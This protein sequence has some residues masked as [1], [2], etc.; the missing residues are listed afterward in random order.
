MSNAV[1]VSIEE[2]LPE[3]AWFSKVEAFVLKILSELNKSDWELSVFFC[4]DAY[5][6]SLNKE[7]R[8]I[9]SATDI[10]SFE[11][12]SEDFPQF[13][14]ADESEPYYAGDI[15]ISLE[16]LPVNAE[17]FGIEKTL[18]LQRLLIHGVLHLSGMDHGEEH[19]EKGKEAEG[20]MLVLQEK[21]LE[22]I[23]E[24]WE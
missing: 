22:K 11:A 20:E 5:I 18:E 23:K 1:N 21:I 9:D 12:D 4:G 6:R 24:N 17:Y 7:Y 10:L 14:Q 19:I 3:P 13:F 15:V 2:N 16:T 8:N